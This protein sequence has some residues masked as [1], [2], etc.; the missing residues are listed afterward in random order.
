MIPYAKTYTSTMRASVLRFVVCEQCGCEYVY[1]M[2]REA[3]GAAT[4]MLFLDNA[5]AGERAENKAEAEL[6]TKLESECDPVPCLNCGWYQPEML[7]GLRES[8]HWWMS[9]VGPLLVFGGVACFIIAS[10]TRNMKAETA[11]IALLLGGGVGLLILGLALIFVRKRLAAAFDPN[12]GNA[13]Q[14]KALG[15]TLALRKADFEK[16]A[17]ERRAA[18]EKPVG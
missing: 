16:L 4:S 12:E 5:G 14:R 1:Q 6:R 8:H 15:A 3:S 9:V 13:E 2:E 7:P 11:T 10:I 17:A 18:N